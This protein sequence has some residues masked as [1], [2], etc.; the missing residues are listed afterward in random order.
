V[1]SRACLLLGVIP[2]VTIP[3]FGM[4]N[5]STRG[6]AFGV[7]FI[8]SNLYGGL[9]D[10]SL[11]LGEGEEGGVSMPREGRFSCR[12]CVIA[13]VSIDDTMAALSLRL[14]DVLKT[15][16]RGKV[17]KLSF[18]VLV[19]TLVSLPFVGDDRGVLQTD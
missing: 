1:A 9:L 7:E 19:N 10:P 16:G 17:T 18:D 5:S 3:F 4:C 2:P 14:I 11:G 6:S 13:A 12:A 15:E 8:P